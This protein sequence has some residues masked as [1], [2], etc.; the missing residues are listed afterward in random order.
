MYLLNK[1]QPQPQQQMAPPPAGIAVAHLLA[2]V[3]V[4]VL[5]KIWVTVALTLQPTAQ[6][7]NR[8]QQIGLRFTH[9]S[10]T[11]ALTLVS[12]LAKAPV[13]TMAPVALTLS[14]FAQC[15]QQPL[16]P[17]QARKNKLM[18]FARITVILTLAIVHARALVSTLATVALT[19]SGT[20]Q[21]PKQPWQQ[22]RQNCPQQP[23]QP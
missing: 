9:V 11:V 13:S 20:A 12:A 2:L 6:L 22:A 14:G 1:Q 8:I 4:T 16:Q 10:I 17:R 21:C 3:H 5:V 7:I 15:P 23:V 19:T 18:C